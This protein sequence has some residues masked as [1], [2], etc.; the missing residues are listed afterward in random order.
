MAKWEV[1]QVIRIRQVVD[2]S[3]A[4]EAI[5]RAALPKIEGRSVSV[6]KVEVRSLGEADES[7]PIYDFTGAWEDLDE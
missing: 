5:Q 6:E 1:E 3:T 2:A 4:E 7:E